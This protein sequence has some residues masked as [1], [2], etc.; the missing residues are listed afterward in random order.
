ML[1]NK[2]QFSIIVPLFQNDGT[3]KAGVADSVHVAMVEFFGGATKVA[4]EGG[5]IDEKDGQFYGDF[6]VTVYAV[7]E[8]TQENAEF[9]RKLARI[10][11]DEMAQECVFIS[12]VPCAMELV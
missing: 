7:G 9:M 11:K 1:I 10:V 4:S 5:W 12:A 6:S 8:F 3:R 2:A